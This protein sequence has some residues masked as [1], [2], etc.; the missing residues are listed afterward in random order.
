MSPLAAAV[1]QCVNTGEMPPR[2]KLKSEGSYN[3]EALI[4]LYDVNG[5]V[6]LKLTPE[7]GVSQIYLGTENEEWL[8]LPKGVYF[9][10]ARVS[11]QLLSKKIIKF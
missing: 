11:G 10:S 2:Y 3:L 7:A 8:G 4:Y 1:N 5:Q 6:K 9:V